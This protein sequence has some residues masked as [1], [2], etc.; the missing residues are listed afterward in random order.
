M[1]MVRV[2]SDTGRPGILTR[3]SDEVYTRLRE[4]ILYG[5]LRPNESLV[6]TELAEWLDVSRTPVR[7]SLLRLAADGLIVSRRRRWVV[8]EHTVDEVREIYEVRAAQE[9]YAARLACQRATEA[10]LTEIADIHRHAP[11]IATHSAEER[12]RYN[13]TFHGRIVEAA[14]NSRLT[15]LIERNRLFYFNNRVAALYDAADLATSDQQ[16]AELVIAL[17]ERDEL[18]AQE[19]TITH[20]QHA[21][22]MILSK[23]Y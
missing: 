4:E 16:H 23:L 21:F 6:E 11:L 5:R 9:G 22:H 19:I 2:S 10:E 13:S 15:D 20:V 8:Y 3:T 12:V 7:E 1:E 14:G 18:R 17:R